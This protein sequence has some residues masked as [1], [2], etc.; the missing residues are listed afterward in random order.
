MDNEDFSKINIFDI[1]KYF[2]NKVTDSSNLKI[3]KLMFFAYIDFFKENK[4]ELFPDDFEAWVYGPVLPRLYKDYNKIL[5]ENDFD[6]VNLKIEK[7]EK[8]WKIL[9]NIIL[10]YGHINPFALV[11]LTHQ[12]AAWEKARE[13]LNKF[14]NSNKKINLRKFLENENT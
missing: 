9:E 14:Q 1:A 7:N 5:L 8:I 6:N 13:G 12:H 4:E 10:K 11:E 2:Y 3:Q